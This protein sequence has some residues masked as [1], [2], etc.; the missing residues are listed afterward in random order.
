[1]LIQTYFD[2]LYKKPLYNDTIH[3]LFSSHNFLSVQRN[4]NNDLHNSFHLSFTTGI[5]Y[6]LHLIQ[7][8]LYIYNYSYLRFS[9]MVAVAAFEF[10]KHQTSQQSVIK[11]LHFANRI[12]A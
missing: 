10:F 7:T 8:P 4:L 11:L 1:M 2:F 6:L 3:I 9:L 5:S 12:E